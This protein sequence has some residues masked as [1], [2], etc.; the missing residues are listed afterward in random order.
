MLGNVTSSW[1]WKY[2]HIRN[3][4]TSIKSLGMVLS[5]ANT[6]SISCYFVF[7]LFQPIFFEKVT[8]H[9]KIWQQCGNF[10]PKKWCTFNFWIQKWRTDRRQLVKLGLLL[11]FKR[12]QWWLTTHHMFELLTLWLIACNAFKSWW[13]LLFCNG[14]V[15]KLAHCVSINNAQKVQTLTQ[16]LLFLCSG[17][18]KLVQRVSMNNAH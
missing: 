13:L 11:C 2:P 6:R 9:L 14:G 17:G 3:I 18:A 10:H 7:L 12:R 1:K 8:V 4:T 5:V 15:R 16:G